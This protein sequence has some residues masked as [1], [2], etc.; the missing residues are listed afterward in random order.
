M[1]FPE[2]CLSR[3]RTK[4]L[5]KVFRPYATCAT[6]IAQTKIFRGRIDQLFRM[7]AL[8]I[9]F[10]PS[11]AAQTKTERDL[12]IYAI[13]NYT[14][15]SLGESNNNDEIWQSNKA[16]VG[17]AAY[18]EN[19]RRNNGLILGGSYTNT[20]SQ[21]MDLGF[22]VFD[23]WTLQRYKAD[24]LYEHRFRSGRAF[25]PYLGLGGFLIILWGG[26]APAHSNVNASGWD[27]LAG[28]IVP[29][30]LTT[31]LNSRVSLKT[32]LFVDIGRA[33]TYGDPTYKSSHNLMY[34]PQIG[35]SFRLGKNRIQ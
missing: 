21:L 29:V 5:A 2:Q 31:R 23:T 3:P 18:F 30:G 34:E 16:V 12:S 32:G 28:L 9:T 26:D 15:P 27:A 14:S 25:Q 10:M 19:W 17:A 24:A 11:V 1:L 22:T 20:N 35:L 6:T 7:L 8:L 13:G 33:S 4:R